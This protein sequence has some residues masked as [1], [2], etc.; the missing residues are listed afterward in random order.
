MRFD[1]I[2]E[3]INTASTALIAVAAVAGILTGLYQL[4][5]WRAQTL[6]AAEYKLAR[7]LLLAVYAVREGFKHVRLPTIYPF[8]FPQHLF[9]ADGTVSHEDHHKAVAYAY[10]QRL[11]LLGEAFQ[12]LENLSLEAEVHWGAQFTNAL[13]EL[14]K[15]RFRLRHV[16]T[17]YVRALDPS[18]RSLRKEQSGK[19]L[20]EQN[21]VLY[22]LGEGPSEHDTFTPEI[23][24]V[25]SYFETF[26][27]P[28]VGTRRL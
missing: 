3:L 20:N 26:L 6:G 8:E 17:E 11:N 7:D 25:V 19:E 5:A 2:L 22:Y 12:K 23:N 13:I 16:I 4:N 14:R 27:R 18:V 1:D 28:L 24:G 10:E 21:S 9:G 15:L